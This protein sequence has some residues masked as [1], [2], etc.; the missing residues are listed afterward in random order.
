[1]SCAGAS[2]AGAATKT[3][4]QPSWHNM[5]RSR[6]HDAHTRCLGARRFL[7]DRLNTRNIIKRKK[8]KLEGNNYNCV[9]CNCNLEETAFHLFF[10]CPFSQACWH[11]MGFDFFE[12][13]IQ[14]KQHLRSPFMEVFIIGAWQIWKQRNNFIFDRGRS[15][16]NFW[17]QSFFR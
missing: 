10:G 15:S 2:T 4:G 14:A 1:M 12:M 6:A 17:K 7:M 9:L 13:I 8:H 3:E 11:P 16:F 5:A